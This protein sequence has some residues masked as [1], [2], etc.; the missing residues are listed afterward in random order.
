MRYSDRKRNIE[1]KSDALVTDARKRL[2]N[3]LRNTEKNII[4][5]RLQPGQG[6]ICNNVLHR[7]SGF[8]DSTNKDKKRLLFRA[9]YL[10]RVSKNICV[11]DN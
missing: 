2:C 3:I 11:E 1:W 8:K 9:R 6:V 10:N 5:L 7:R 4:R